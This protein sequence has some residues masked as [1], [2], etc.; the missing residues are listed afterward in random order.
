MALALHLPLPWAPLLLCGPIP[1][2][3]DM[4]HWTLEVTID[5]PER[6]GLQQLLLPLPALHGLHVKSYQTWAHEP[7][8]CRAS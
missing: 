4:S 2:F 8:A 6:K 3:R 7:P 5:L 1:R